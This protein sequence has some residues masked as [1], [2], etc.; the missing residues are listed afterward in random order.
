MKNW[1]KGTNA[2]VLSIAVVAVFILLMV[3]LHSAK[4]VQWDMTSNKSFTLSEQTNTTLKDLDQKVHVVVFTAPGA[5]YYTR[6]ITDLLETYHK[7]NSNLTWESVDPAKKPSIAEKYEVTDYGTIVMEMGTNRKTY[8]YSDIF[9]MNAAQTGYDFAGEQVL[10]QGIIG[11]TSKEKTNVYVLTGQGEYSST[12]LTQLTK[13]LEGENY[14][15]TDLNLLKEA[16]IPDDAKALY[17]LDPK[18]DLTDAEAK[19]VLDYVKGD[20][21]LMMALG[22]TKDMETWKNWND[23]LA[24]VGVKNV[25][26]L[27]VESKKSLM[28][29]PLTIIPEYGNHDITDKLSQANE[30][31]VMPASIALKETD[32]HEGLTLTPLL[33]TSSDSYGKTNV[34]EILNAAQQLT[35]KDIAKA[36]ADVAGPLDLAFAVED[37]NSKPKAVVIGNGIFLGDQWFTQYGNRDFFMNSAGWLQEQKGGITI[38]AREDVAVKQALLTP[39]KSNTIFVLTVAVIPALFLLA[40]GTIWWRRRRA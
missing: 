26:A 21:K 23:V 29:D 13:S 10:T 11:F 5:D 12:E 37:A 7:K 34:N 19:L 14:V 6:Q 8:S 33:T 31:L 39:A 24:A 16:K 1:L 18:K 35:E 15:V 38:R 27:A 40:G 22:V 9:T 30:S 36:A 25:Q 32:K 3:F 2:A 4:D 20:G 28:T 17:V